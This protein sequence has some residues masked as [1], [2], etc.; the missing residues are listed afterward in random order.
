MYM[1]TF[2]AKSVPMRRRWFRQMA[3]D[4]RHGCLGG[5]PVERARE[6][7]ITL[8]D[9]SMISSPLNRNELISVPFKRI[10]YTA[11]SMSWNPTFMFPMTHMMR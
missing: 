6:K 7:F 8:M 10:G 11:K 5:V 9:E 3:E 1:K 4:F 2:S